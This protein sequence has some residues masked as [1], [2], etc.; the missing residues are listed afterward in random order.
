[1][2]PSRSSSAS[3]LPVEAP[4][5]TMAL[6]TGAGSQTDLDFNG[7]VAARIKHLTAVDIQNLRHV[8]S[9]V[10]FKKTRSF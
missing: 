1:L 4:E 9:P 6:P 10:G 3:L 2:S 5:G 8:V 7:G